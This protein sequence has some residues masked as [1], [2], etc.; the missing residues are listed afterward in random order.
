M[1]AVTDPA[2]KP[3]TTKTKR[4]MDPML[5]AAAKLV[6]LL[7]E[8]PPAVRSWAMAYAAIKYQEKDRP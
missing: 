4:E 3:A 6:R 1:T 2:P 5:R 8:M 7:E